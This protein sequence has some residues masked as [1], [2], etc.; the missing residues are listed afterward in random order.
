MFFPKLGGTDNSFL[1]D[2]EISLEGCHG[3]NL[4]P[5]KVREGCLTSSVMRCASTNEHHKNVS[6]T[7]IIAIFD[8]LMHIPVAM[9][10]RH[11]YW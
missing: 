3:P 5:P 9:N 10:L 11:M 2:S 1:L 4:T 8:I 7:P 6:S